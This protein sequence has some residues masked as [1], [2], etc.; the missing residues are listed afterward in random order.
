[1]SDQT[2]KGKQFSRYGHTW[3]SNVEA[4]SS[5]AGTGFYLYFQRTACP[6]VKKFCVISYFAKSGLLASPNSTQK[7]RLISQWSFQMTPIATEH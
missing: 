5:I 4:M 6:S 1:M 3:K 2:T 7:H